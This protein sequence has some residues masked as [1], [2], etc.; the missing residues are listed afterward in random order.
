MAGTEPL[1]I[2]VVQ[3]HRKSPAR[4]DIDLHASLSTQSCHE[5]AGHSRTSHPLLAAFAWRTSSSW[6]SSRTDGSGRQSVWIENGIHLSFHYDGA[7]IP[8]VNRDWADERWPRPRT[9]TS[10]S[11]SPRG[12]RAAQ[13]PSCGTVGQL[14]RFSPLTKIEQYLRSGWVGGWMRSAPGGRRVR[15]RKKLRSSAPFPQKGSIERKLSRLWGPGRAVI[16]HAGVT[17]L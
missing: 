10:V 3:Q 14:S 2:V 8:S 4:L 1:G 15:S 13:H 16:A 12:R 5:P 6:R 11:S 17:T 7:R 9:P